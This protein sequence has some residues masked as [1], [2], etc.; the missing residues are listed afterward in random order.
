MI[1]RQS[2]RS[3]PI[4]L[5]E[6]SKHRLPRERLG[7]TIL[8]KRLLAFLKVFAV[9][10][11][12]QQLYKH[13]LL[14]SVFTCFVS[15][16][17]SATAQ[18]ALSCV[19][20][21]KQPFVTP[22]AEQLRNM[23][24][25][26]ELRDTM[27]KFNMSKE[28]KAIDSEH[29]ALLLPLV[30][31]ILFGRLSAKVSISKASKE[32]PSARRAAV[33]SFLSVLDGNDDELYPLFYLMVR[34]YIPSPNNLKPVE[35]QDEEDRQN[36]FVWL[37][38]MQA[39]NVS[40]LRDQRHEGFLN[41]LSSGIA[42]LGHSIEKF[43][44]AF[45]SILLALCKYS[46]I[47]QSADVPNGLDVSETEE[48]A[49]D[50]PRGPTS[51]QGVVRTLCFRR[52]AELHEKF[53]S[54]TDFLPYAKSLWESLAL[55]VHELPVT[56]AYA[57]RAPALLCLLQTLS[58]H[59][60]LIPILAEHDEAVPSVIKCI[61]D[62]SKPSVANTS[63]D[64]VECLL[65]NGG[66]EMD[67]DFAAADSVGVHLIQKHLSLLLNQFAIRL[68]SKNLQSEQSSRTM[69]DSE[70]TNAV[71]SHYTRWRELSILC[72]VSGLVVRSDRTHQDSHDGVHEQEV[73]QMLCELLLPFL[74]PVRRI[75]EVD[76]LNVIG[77]LS[78][79][80]PRIGRQT[81]RSH[82][83]ALSRLL[84]PYKGRRGISS[85][86]VRKSVASVIQTIPN[87]P[88]E[89]NDLEAVAI[90]TVRLCAVHSKRVDE[91]DSD[92]VVSALSELGTADKSSK[93][94]LHISGTLNEASPTILS[95][96]ISSCFHF[97]YDEDGVVSRAAFQALKSLILCAAVE[98]KKED[99]VTVQREPSE[100]PNTW[101]KLI[102][103]SV[104]P[105]CRSGLTSRS[106]P[107]RR[108]FIFL[109]AEVARRLKEY[110]SPNLYGDLSCLIRDDEPDLDFFLNVT[111]VQIHRRSRAFQRLCKMLS[112]SDETCSPFS[113]Q[114]LSSVLLPL[115][116]HPIYESKTRA[117]ESLVLEAVKTV[118]AIA[119]HLSWSKYHATLWT[120]LTQ[121]ER[122][123]EQE[124]YLIEAI[125]SVIDAFHFN[126]VGETNNVANE[127]VVGDG[128][129]AVRRA[130]E[131]RIIPKT[132][133]L[134]IKEK[135]DRSGGT[136]TSLRPS[137]V[138]ALLKLFQ[139]FPVSFF[140]ARLTRLLVVICDA[141]KSKDSDARDVA[142]KTLAKMTA[143]MDISYLREVIRQL[144]VTLTE[145]YRL[146]VRMAT[147][148]SILQELAKS[149]KSPQVTSS[150]KE[151]ETPFD[152]CIPAMMDLIQQDV[153]G[154]ARERKETDGAKKR[155]VK[156][157]IGSKSMDSIELICRMLLFKPSSH[158]AAAKSVSAVHAV[159]SP[160][161]QR[162]RTPDIDTSTIG[163]IGECLTRVVVGLSHNETVSTEEVLPFVY[164]SISPFVGEYQA[165][166]IAD[167]K[168]DGDSSDNEQF[169]T[170]I[171]ISRTGT[172]ARI[173]SRSSNQ[174]NHKKVNASNVVEWRPST[175]NVAQNS[176]DAREM[177]KEQ[178]VDLHR[179]RDGASAPKLTGSNRIVSAHMPSAKGL[180]D[181]AGISAVT[182]GLSLL[183]S[184]LK[185]A[186]F[187]ANDNVSRGMLD[188]FIPML[189]TCVCGCRNNEVILLS[190]RC[191][192]VLLRMDLPSVQDFS[193]TLGTETL[194][195]LTSCGNVSNLHQEITQ[196][197]FKTLTLLISLDAV[198]SNKSSTWS[199]SVI[200]NGESVLQ[201]GRAMPL[202]A[203]QMQILIS[204]LKAAL[205]ESDHYHPTL[206]LIK[207]I[208]SRQFVSSEF[209]DLMDTMLDLSVRSQKATVRQVRYPRCRVQETT[210]FRI[211]TYH[212]FMYC[213]SS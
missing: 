176:G 170:D 124:R 54:S 77:I 116:M 140:E 71:N 75:S 199:T 158:A 187:D 186:K 180:N 60:R 130:L 72:R 16:Q 168:S 80:F 57:D 62:T 149:Y 90:V 19:L 41:L 206:F 104:V 201:M 165:A 164:A 50:K 24:K 53:A 114:S 126:L 9:V 191:L 161:L 171:Q 23:L 96:L 150:E 44:P 85:L 73:L 151:V 81:A 88:G 22:Y 34:S 28:S 48:G 65:S 143:E 89:R 68:G 20:K 196:G 37:E 93:G 200:N 99:I 109:F 183:N 10:N 97:L 205:F 103:T 177:K 125:C 154:T 184:S 58:S 59:P 209:Y 194:D 111:H 105:V 47:K 66:E 132:E 113:M 121:F 35:K 142:R 101:V 15:H 33:M 110:S 106:Q 4:S 173:N 185:R 117:E 178:R 136:V 61:S 70:Q 146:H 86:A 123:K 1:Q 182:F 49:E 30:T 152:S 190:L 5:I 69:A 52:L 2:L 195:I 27:L 118:G 12:P 193:A 56:V 32:T 138:L 82:L 160:V 204:V 29:R 189:T 147:L 38:S 203:E 36:T 144:A 14:L 175:L 7:R 107:I 31:R 112:E 76:Q 162:L 212:A 157:A 120:L 179:V 131:R 122:H 100:N 128:N 127:D 6:F 11:G 64:F 94:W 159:V 198:Q 42:Q 40:H 166:T 155:V 163:R 153:F 67:E 87:F 210:C 78:S 17:D 156:E 172:S 108:L 3:F 181:P 135:T 45:M 129:N 133:S 74:S 95:P 208:V 79:L 174:K 207:A 83:P 26:G 91:I 188:P 84:G 115:S 25:K 13:G 39:D 197:C 43:V 145:G 211:S 51:R 92:E 98:A 102:E 55:S 134:L 192:G 63:L 202:D 119:R 137:V 139:K 167:D 21:F 213:L 148:H 46:Q 8:D 141:L 169:E 18:A